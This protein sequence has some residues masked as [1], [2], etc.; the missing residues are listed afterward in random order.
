M[1][2][3][4]T[5]MQAV[6]AAVQ[7]ALSG[8]GYEVDN[9]RIRRKPTFD[10]MGGG[11]KLVVSQV[12][13][14]YVGDEATNEQD[15]VGYGVLISLGQTVGPASP[16]EYTDEFDEVI[17]DRETLRRYFHNTAEQLTFAGG[18]A[19]PAGLFYIGLK[20]EPGP[21]LMAGHHENGIDA[22]AIVLRVLVRETHE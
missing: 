15:D 10:G 2:V 22:T 14:R 5:I 12:P 18:S 6:M 8:R 9:M 11:K 7:L 21:M 3:Q 16:N 20:V 1:S 17:I 19:L 4:K 13:E